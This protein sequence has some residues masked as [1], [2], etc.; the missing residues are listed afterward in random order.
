V[1]LD[2][3]GGPARPSAWLAVLA[4]LAVGILMAV[5]IVVVEGAKA[6]CSGR[7]I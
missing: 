2:A 3:A 5:R 1:A 7:L 4:L 6:R